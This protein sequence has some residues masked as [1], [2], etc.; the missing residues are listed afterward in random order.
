MK[1]L[2]ISCGD[3]ATEAGLRFAALGHHVTGWRRNSSK[4]PA[5]LH[6]ED[7][8][9]QDQRPWP[10]IDPD[11]EVVL[12]TP[13]PSSRD[14]PGY[15]RAYLQVA[16][17]LV[18][19]LQEQAPNL[20][21]LVYVSS[22]AVSGGDHGEWIDESTPAEPNRETSQILALTEQEFLG[23]GLPVTILRASGIYGPGRNHLITQVRNGTARLP[24]GS[25]WTNRIHRDDLAQAIVHVA[26]MGE[27]ADELYMVTDNEPA[28]LEDI[29]AFLSA[30]LDLPVPPQAAEPSTRRAADRRVKNSKLLSTGFAL[31]FPGYREGYR[32]VLAEES[33][34]HR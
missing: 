6:G 25:H 2:L 26:S 24:V 17:R 16:R 9:L 22:T 29:F 14:V 27:R 15:E 21:R 18:H 28:Q 4:L 7:V 20:K 10:R 8:D 34:R 30:Q 11:T 1:V 5:T 31:E 13:V 33:I 12:L 3:V 23:S 19:A 32:S